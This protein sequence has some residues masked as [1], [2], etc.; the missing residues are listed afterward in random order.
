MDT[1]IVANHNTTTA[2]PR[3]D[4]VDAHQHAMENANM[5]VE[6][7]PAVGRKSRKV[8]AVPETGETIRMRPRREKVKSMKTKLTNPRKKQLPTKVPKA[9]NKS[10]NLSQKTTQ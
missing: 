7:V 4:E 9:Q 3:V 8:V 6:A 1:C 5:T 2:I 10:L